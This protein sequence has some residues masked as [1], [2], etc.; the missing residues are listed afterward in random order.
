M[1]INKV[2]KCHSTHDVNSFC[3]LSQ[4]TVTLSYRLDEEVS[5]KL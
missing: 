2:A 5:L 1:S 3:L 4:E